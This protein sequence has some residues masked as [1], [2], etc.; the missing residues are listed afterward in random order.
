MVDPDRPFTLRDPYEDDVSGRRGSPER[1]TSSITS[2]RYLSPIWSMLIVIAAF[3]FIGLIA[4]VSDHREQ[5]TQQRAPQMQTI[6]LTT[7]SA[8][9]R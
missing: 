4:L 3:A 2:A 6:P 5:Q 9:A 7:G 1:M 8:P